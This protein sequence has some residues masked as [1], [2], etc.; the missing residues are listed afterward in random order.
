[1]LREA[2]R[3]I[4]FSIGRHERS[5][6]WIATHVGREAARLTV[7]RFPVQERRS[8]AVEGG[9]RREK[10]TDE[11]KSCVRVGKYGSE[12]VAHAFARFT[13]TTHGNQR[14]KRKTAYRE[15]SRFPRRLRA[16]AYAPPRA[17]SGDRDRDLGTLL[18]RRA[19]SAC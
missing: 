1:M 19:C 7:Y 16:G 13:F 2:A 11:R 18:Q 8:T 17:G 3:E 9:E 5:I 15:G 14:R 12:R 10:K 6:R 4:E